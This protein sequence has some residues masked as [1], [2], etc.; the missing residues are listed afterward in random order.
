MYHAWT[1]IKPK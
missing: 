1:A